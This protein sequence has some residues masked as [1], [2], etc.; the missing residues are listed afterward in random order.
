M[1]YSAPYENWK[2]SK[3][4]HRGN[5]TQNE[6]FTRDQLMRPDFSL[7][8]NR[9]NRGP[10]ENTRRFNSTNSEQMSQYY[11][12]S[13]RYGWNEWI[14]QQKLKSSELAQGLNESYSQPVPGSEY[15]SKYYLRK[16]TEP[17][18]CSSCRR[19]RKF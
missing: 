13:D 6:S 8:T 17:G 2:N 9:V 4:D 19:P 16:G 14:K 1:G 5:F 3:T 18:G 7:E 15:N 11:G 10:Y 12:N